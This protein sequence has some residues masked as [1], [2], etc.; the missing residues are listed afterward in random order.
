MSNSP[1]QPLAQARANCERFVKLFEG[2][3]L[4][5]TVAGSVRRCKPM[6]GDVEHVIIPES[7]IVTDG[8]FGKPGSLVLERADT[9][10]RTGVIS[11]AIYSDGKNRW[12][13]KYRGVVFEGVRHEL[14][15][16]DRD[17]FGAILA[18]R[19]GPA[20]F[21]ERLV[22]ILKQGGKYRQADGYVRRTSEGGGVDFSRDGLVPV[23]NEATF[24]KLCGMPPLAPEQRDA[25][26]DSL[27]GCQEV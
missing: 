8:L 7:G 5:W 25:Y 11:K 22:T 27:K 6:V 21:S 24:F 17:N 3:F 16:A 1:R 15:M 12:G 14:F 23:P 26:V 9:L 19:T 13:D 2:T 4:S 18:I 10:V 20:E